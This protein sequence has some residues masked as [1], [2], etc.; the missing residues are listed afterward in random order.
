MEMVKGRKR[1]GMIDKIYLD[2]RTDD[3]EA[4]VKLD[5]RALISFSET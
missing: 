3:G 2:V 5:G 4:W 1:R